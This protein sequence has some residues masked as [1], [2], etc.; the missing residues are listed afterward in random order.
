[1]IRPVLA[2]LSFAVLAAPATAASYPNCLGGGSPG[3]QVHV[4][5]GYGDRSSDDQEVFDKMRLRQAGIAADSVDRT[6]L[7]CMKVQR[8]ENGRWVTEYY[9]PDTV[10]SGPLDLTLR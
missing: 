9:N 7:G 2:A 8:F 3:L 1:M 6:W 5:I 4:E 10:E